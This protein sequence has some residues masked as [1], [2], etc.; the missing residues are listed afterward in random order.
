[1]QSGKI[2]RYRNHLRSIKS[3]QKVVQTRLQICKF[4]IYAILYGG[5]VLICVIWRSGSRCSV[6][7]CRVALARTVLIPR[8]DREGL[9]DRF[10]QV[11]Q[12]WPKDCDL[13]VSSISIQI[14]RFESSLYM[15]LVV[16][17]LPVRQRLVFG[18]SDF[19]HA[20]F[21]GSN[22][23]TISFYLFAPTNHLFLFPFRKRNDIS[24]EFCSTYLFPHRLCESADKQRF[25]KQLCLVGCLLIA[26]LLVAI[27]DPS[28]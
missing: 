11:L 21:Q 10:A 6:V 5:C 27:R 9:Y 22:S 26:Q 20:S 28:I 19:D 8:M 3:C 24:R 14:R 16:L 15:I 7:S 25:S 23:R 13:A 1:M 12:A 4:R 18:A 2:T 17:W